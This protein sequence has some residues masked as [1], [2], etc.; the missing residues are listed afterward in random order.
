MAEIAAIWPAFKRK[1]SLIGLGIC[2]EYFV[3][4]DIPKGSNE[5]G[6]TG[7]GKKIYLT[8]DHP[9]I[10]ALPAIEE[11]LTFIKGVFLH[12][13]MHQIE[14]D[15]GATNRALAKLKSN[16]QK[17]IM[18][19]IFNVIE[20]PS[21][22]YH[23]SKYMGG[24]ALAALHFMVKK[25][26]QQHEVLDP[27]DPPFGQYMQALIQYGDGGLLKGDFSDPEAKRIFTETIPIID[28]AIE[29]PVG[30]KRIKIGVEVFE[31]T[32]PLWEKS[33]AEQ[34]AL[35][36]FLK[37]LMSELGKSDATSSGADAAIKRA[38]SG[39][40][41]GEEEDPASAA[42]KRKRK[43]T[44]R[45]VSKEEAEELLKNGE[46]S[47]SIPPEGD[48]EILIVED[49]DSTPTPG[50]SGRVPIPSAGS[51]KKSGKD[52]PGESGSGSGT[53]GDNPEKG[54]DDSS[55]KS[56]DKSSKPSEED[57][58]SGSSSGNAN[59]EE[60]GAPE[61]KNSDASCGSTTEEYTSSSVNS[62]ESTGSNSS[63]TLT[64]GEDGSAPE[65]VGAGC[66][67]DEDY[68]L[69]D[70]QIDAINSDI[71]ECLSEIKS[72]E[73][74]MADVDRENMD[75]TD[76][77][78]KYKGVSCKNLHS[79]A[80]VE[81]LSPSYNVLVSAMKPGITRLTSQLQRIIRND[82]DDVAYRNSGRVN[83][84]R[85]SDAR[86]TSR[87]FDRR[88][89][90][91]NKADMAV[92]L[93]VDCSGSMYGSKI[94]LARECAI[95][96]AEV[97]ANLNIPLKVIGFTSDTRGYDV[98]HFHYVNWS[99]SRSERIKLLDLEAY[100]NNFDGYS[101]RYAGK[102]IAKRPEQNKL[103]VVISDGQPACHFY[104]GC[105]GISDTKD[106]IR[107]A[108][109]SATVVGVAIDAN[110]NE[111]Y[112]MY[113]ASFLHVKNVSEMFENIGARIRKE[114]KQ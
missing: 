73:R 3:I 82:T 77:P 19:S 4:C 70:E 101:I 102:L 30:S 111:L 49:D 6:Y 69:S 11:K 67:D 63:L 36:E 41:E 22:E 113:G 12:E 38:L 17:R 20:D 110:V 103:I 100:S 89:E 88:V 85:L 53:E 45:K 76:M 84:K 83:I 29:E 5:I 7:A 24:D 27:E 10:N 52:N 60:D 57:G 56:S 39:A 99:K 95:G 104:S 78:S 35:E 71:S 26:Y 47:S 42:R 87:V 112:N 51:D 92:M 93:V 32:R 37:K 86:L 90:P 75:V 13:L 62:G 16:P 64:Y 14:T 65:D 74:E 107:E 108:S 48:L 66:T 25:V 55:G 94:K 1:L 33:A 9:I 96:L 34:E 46:A 18:M 59:S 91:S 106:A 28:N 114:M 21:I 58:D 72:E 61:R 8:Y 40:S 97:F 44:Y 79:S 2:G 80:N 50:K 23:A 98:V 54:S 68:E 105:T 31:K 81:R 15:F 43:I 109:K